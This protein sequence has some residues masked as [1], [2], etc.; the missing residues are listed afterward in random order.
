[1][2]KQTLRAWLKG[3]LA[4]VIGGIANAVPVAIIAPESFNFHEGLPK[5]A[6]VTFASA[7]ISAAFYLKQSPVPRDDEEV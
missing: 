7:L 2:A 3:L 4:A 5:L 6:S 1:M